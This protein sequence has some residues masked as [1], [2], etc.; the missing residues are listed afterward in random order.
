M[1]LAGQHLTHTHIRSKN[2]TS[3]TKS[4]LCVSL[5]VPLGRET[6]VAI[7]IIVAK[8]LLCI[9]RPDGLGENKK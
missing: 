3:Y 9:S 2:T 7:Y 8:L 1:H 6:D 4:I 5:K